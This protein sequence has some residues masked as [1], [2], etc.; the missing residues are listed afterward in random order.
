LAFNIEAI[1]HDFHDED[2]LTMRFGAK[3]H[4]HHLV[5]LF[6][7]SATFDKKSF[8]FSVPVYANPQQL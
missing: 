3:N 1:A 7:S 6:T 4:R 8:V 2:L 5:G